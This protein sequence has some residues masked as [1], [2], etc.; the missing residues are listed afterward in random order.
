M[1][2]SSMIPLAGA[3]LGGSPDAQKQ[4]QAFNGVN[5]QTGAAGAPIQGAGTPSPGPTGGQPAQNPGLL[6]SMVQALLAQKASSPQSMGMS[7]PTASPTMGAL[8]SQP[9]TQNFGISGQ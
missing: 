5:S 3:F 1:D 7:G 9:P 6:G 2:F 4:T 8:F